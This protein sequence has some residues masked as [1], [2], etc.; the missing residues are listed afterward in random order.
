MMRSGIFSRVDGRTAMRSYARV[1]LSTMV[2]S[3]M[4]QSM[5]VNASLPA[6]R[7]VN[8]RQDVIHDAACSR[9]SYRV[10]RTYVRGGLS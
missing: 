10:S 7:R 4:I 5:L 8:L 9:N 2:V 6:V 1:G 3:R